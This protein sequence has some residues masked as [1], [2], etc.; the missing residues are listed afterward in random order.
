M[1]TKITSTKDISSRPLLQFSQ[2]NDNCP[3]SIN[4]GLQS[5]A[6]YTKIR[7]MFFEPVKHEKAVQ[8]GGFPMFSVLQ[9]H[10]TRSDP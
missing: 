6:F 5:H 7:S 10:E 4:I 3:L 2:L 1:Y 8:P 9:E